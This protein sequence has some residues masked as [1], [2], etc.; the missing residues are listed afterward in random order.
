MP[1]HNLNHV[2][3][4]ITELLKTSGQAEGARVLIVKH[5]V[6]IFNIESWP[7]HFNNFLALEVPG[8]VVSVTAN[9]ASASGFSVRIACHD[10]NASR[11]DMFVEAYV[12]L[13]FFSAALFLGQF[14]LAALRG[15]LEN[16][17]TVLAI[18]ELFLAYNHTPGLYG[19]PVSNLTRHVRG[20]MS[21]GDL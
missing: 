17:P 14:A 16:P 21:M 2:A 18:D 4:I 20:F 19:A 9:S 15:A 10:E 7:S 3:E 8:A 12:M 13:A 6:E 5:G 1:Y 11:R